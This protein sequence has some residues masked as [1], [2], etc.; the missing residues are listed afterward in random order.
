MDTIE[1]LIEEFQNL[2]YEQKHRR[3]D[4]KGPDSGFY[5]MPTEI[6]IELRM[7]ELKRL[8]KSPHNH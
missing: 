5:A 8:I 7:E 2:K 1:I 3:L 4:Y 6:A